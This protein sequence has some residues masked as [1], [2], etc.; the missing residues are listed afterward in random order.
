MKNI[1]LNFNNV[2][3]IVPKAKIDGFKLQS[4][5]ATLPCTKKQVKAVTFWDGSI[6]PDQLVRQN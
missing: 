5:A 4:E 2:Y 1:S 3:G 6:Y